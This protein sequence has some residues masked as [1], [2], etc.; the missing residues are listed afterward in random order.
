MPLFYLLVREKS[1]YLIVNLIRL[2]ESIFLWLKI[3]FAMGLSEIYIL[4]YYYCFLN[5]LSNFKINNVIY[6]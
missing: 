4:L 5:A 3:Q 2:L 1:I 6:I